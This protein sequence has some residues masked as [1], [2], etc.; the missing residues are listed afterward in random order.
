MDHEDRA[1][2]LIRRMGL[3]YLFGGVDADL[4]S[5][6]T[7][8]TGREHIADWDEETG[9]VWLLRG[10][11]AQLGEAWYGEWLR[12]KGTFVAVALLP[13][14]LRWLGTPADEQG[15]VA[16]A[17][18]ASPEA[19]SLFEAL[20]VEGPLSS[21]ELRR[22]TDLTGAERTATFS[23]ALTALRRRML[24]TT[25]GVEGGGSGWDSAVYELTAR[26]FAVRP[27]DDEDAAL[28]T[29]VGAYLSATPSKATAAGATRL[30]HNLRR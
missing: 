27:V 2:E 28:E 25:Y 5:L 22:A 3:A 7:E 26:A 16:L 29:L 18:A 9:K 20:L 4:P 12:R 11:L 6:H 30:F 21:V 17:G 15:G 24:I 13:A 23:R 10:R 8:L 19:R 1:V 14:A